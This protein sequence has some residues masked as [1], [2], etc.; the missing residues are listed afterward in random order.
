MALAPPSS[1][2]M[3][4]PEMKMHTAPNPG[5]PVGKPHDVSFDKEKTLMRTI[6]TEGEGEEAREGS[7]VV[8]HVD[9]AQPDSEGKLKRMYCSRDTYPDGVRFELGRSFYSGAH[10]PAGAGANGTFEGCCCTTEPLQRPS[11]ASCHHGSCSQSASVHV[12]LCSRAQRHSSA[13]STS[14]SLA[15]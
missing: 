5:P 8:V 11:R 12:S 7:V 13:P 15:Q 14:A 10:A 2:A 9:I 1:A 3:G 4:D 6:S